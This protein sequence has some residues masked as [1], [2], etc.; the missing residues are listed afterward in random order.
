MNRILY[1][2][3]GMALIITLVM[4]TLLTGWALNLNIKVRDSLVKT[5]GLKKRTEL[6]DK[7]CAGVDIAKLIL[8]RD[9]ENT[10]NDSIQE[11]W[12]DDERISE[13]LFN[14]GFSKDELEIKIIDELSKIQI[15]A[16]VNF[17]NLKKSVQV[18]LWERFLDG[19]RYEFPE[20]IKNPYDII[21]PLL[22]WLDYNEDD[23]I[24]GLTGAEKGY[25]ESKKQMETPR[26]GPMKSVEELSFV[27]GVNEKLW[28]KVSISG[29]ADNYLTT[30]GKVNRSGN[31]FFYEGKININTA[32][33]A[34]ITAL[35]KDKAQIQAAESVVSFRDEKSE[36]K[37]VHQLEKKWYKKC[38]GCTDIKFQEDLITDSSDIF[39]II[40]TA[41]D[42]DY[43]IS[44]ETIIQR[45]KGKNGKW[46]CEILKWV[47]D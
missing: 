3:K 25:Y 17:P 27:R 20:L 13:F 43:N 28:N 10:Q 26:N 6:Y 38:P 47:M 39:K 18:K 24:T 41:K 14:L 34:V 15:N 44:I 2:Q 40:S 31:S 33:A 30:N 5:I 36:G 29:M 32:P 7:A 37:F 16:L 8:I 1:S 11:F 22:D 19:L 46:E 45:K 35:V 42:G 9:K 21:N 4:V 23:A 12:A